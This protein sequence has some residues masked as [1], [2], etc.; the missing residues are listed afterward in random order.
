MHEEP[1]DPFANDPS[2]P[3]PSLH[4]DDEEAEPL[5]EADRLGIIED[6]ADLEVYQ[7]LLAPTGIRGL[8]IDCEDCREEHFF[9]WD[10]LRANLQHLLSHDR[11]RVHERAYD[12]DPEHYVSWDYARGYRDGVEDTL[13]G[14]AED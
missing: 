13:S 12:P 10:L 14:E 8:V 1:I 3:V 4:D 2:D 7:T 11:P 5:T 6:L 9:E